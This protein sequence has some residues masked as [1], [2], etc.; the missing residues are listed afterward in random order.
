[1]CI[2]GFEAWKFQNACRCHGN[3]K[4]TQF[5]TKVNYLTTQGSCWRVKKS[6]C[7]CPL[8]FVLVPKETTKLTISLDSRHQTPN[9]LNET[10]PKLF[11]RVR[12]RSTVFIFVTVSITSLYNGGLKNEYFVVKIYRC[13]TVK[14]V[15]ISKA[16]YQNYRVTSTSL[17]ALVQSKVGS[18]KV[19]SSPSNKSPG[20]L[21]NSPYGSV[22]GKIT[23]VLFHLIYLGFD[24]GYPKRLLT[25]WIWLVS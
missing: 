21:N 14:T 4:N 16:T 8:C 2:N 11:S 5:N 20:L 12:I 10:I 9:K 22:L 6:A 1:M 23:S 15:K 19:T 17:L 13:F 25:L 18:H 7:G 24:G 3:R